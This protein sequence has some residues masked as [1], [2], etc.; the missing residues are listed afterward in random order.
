MRVRIKNDL[1]KWN[2]TRHQRIRPLSVT[3]KE[4]SAVKLERKRAGW[5]HRLRIEE[6]MRQAMI[7]LKGEG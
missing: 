6:G 5:A 1:S 2:A 7:P 3:R 4:H